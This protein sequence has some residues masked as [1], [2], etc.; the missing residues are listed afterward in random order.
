MTAKILGL[1]K[2]RAR[3]AKKPDGLAPGI[4]RDVRAETYHSWTREPDGRFY[5]SNSRI[6][7]L[8][9]RSP[10]HLLHELTTPTEKKSTWE[11]KIG[12]LVDLAIL[13]PLDFAKYQA[14]PEGVKKDSW[15]YEDLRARFGEEC[16][17]KEADYSRIVGMAAAVLRHPAA[18]VLLNHAASTPQ[19]SLVWDDPTTGARCKGRPDLFLEGFGPA[20]LNIVVDLKT[21]HD[22]SPGAFFRSVFEF[23]YYRQLAYYK[24]GFE[25]LGKRVDQCLLLVVESSAPYCVAVYQLINEVLLAGDQ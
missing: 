23:G 10:V 21:T 25:A 6:N 7:K 1:K 22:G 9:D 24:R 19:I 20:G 13:S 11:M 4:Y 16:L 5:I 2:P 17:V 18:S 14:L 12:T 8:I 15:K 3:A